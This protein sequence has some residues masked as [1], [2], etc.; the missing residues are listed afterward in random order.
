[1]EEEFN[2]E[3]DQV[4]QEYP[5]AEEFQD[6]Y[7]DEQRDLWDQSGG[8]YP[9]ANKPDSLYSLFKS[10]WRAKDSTKVGNLDKNELG[11]ALYSV[12]DAKRIALLADVLKHKKF[13]QH[14]SL[15]GEINLA[16]SMSKAGWFPELFVS[17]KK[18]AFKGVS[19]LPNLQNQGQQ[20]NQQQSKGGL[21]R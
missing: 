14:F 16:T 5:D 17:S 15:I 6:N 3:F 12:R 21:F 1:M 18:S 2:T 7:Q 10:V 11:F 9:A 19:N 20:N 13:G 8:S 4:E